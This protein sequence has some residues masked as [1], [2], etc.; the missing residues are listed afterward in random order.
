MG[1]CIFCHK[2]A[3][4]FKDRHP[5]CERTNIE[6]RNE[7]HEAKQKII[8]AVTDT[9]FKNGSF[10]ILQQVISAVKNTQAFS[11]EQ[12]RPLLIKG[13]EIS[14]DKFLDDNLLTDDEEKKLSDFTTHYALTQGDLNDHGA[15]L[16]VVKASV[17]REVMN[18]VVPQKVK[19]QGNLPINLQK[20]E[21]VVWVFTNTEYFE[22]KTKRQ[23]IGGSQGMSVRVMKGVYYRVGAFK[24]Q[25]VETTERM[26][27][28]SGWLAAT[29]KNIYF[30]GQQKSFRVPYQKI[31]SFEPYN[32]GI[33]IMRDA[34]TA[35]A[36]TFIT[37][38][39]WFAYNLCTNIAK[40]FIAQ[41]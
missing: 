28:D 21:Q 40:L 8:D 27:L 20:D 9:I 18:G 37:G 23:F 2:P 13:W 11:D 17:L 19:I 16:K 22:D 15:Y 36:Q 14:V 6:E 26:H 3:G 33:G 39:G 1:D 24:G 12:I 34:S 41:G 30:H 10:D 5:E 29:T 31:V 38:D 4:W 25:S 35:K 7:Q 32:D